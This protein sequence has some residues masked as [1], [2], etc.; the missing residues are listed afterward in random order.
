MML[1][2]ML[3]ACFQEAPEEN[4]I[5]PEGS[6]TN[7]TSETSETSAEEPP[8]QLEAFTLLFEEDDGTL[9]RASILS[10]EGSE[11][12]WELGIE[13]DLFDLHS[14]GMID[15]SVLNGQDVTLTITYGEWE[16][17]DR[18]ILISDAEGPVYVGG[19]GA[20]ELIQAHLGADLIAYGETVAEVVESTAYGTALLGYTM[21]DV[22]TDEGTLSVLPGELTPVLIDGQHWELI[23][24][25]AYMVLGEDSEVDCVTRVPVLSVEMIRTDAARQDTLERPDG[26]SK[27]E[28]GCG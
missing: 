20:V 14:P 19:T 22:Q 10:V 16:Q 18:S 24:H 1:S 9:E 23:V 7:E 28:Y 6:E 4:P 17:D 5:E 3:I 26:F 12:D 27:P 15:L 2:M 25:S 8:P 11:R 13:G 21:V